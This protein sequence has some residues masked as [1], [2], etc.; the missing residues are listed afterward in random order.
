ML[1]WLYVCLGVLI[2]NGQI[3]KNSIVRVKEYSCNLISNKK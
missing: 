1:G 3:K 2:E